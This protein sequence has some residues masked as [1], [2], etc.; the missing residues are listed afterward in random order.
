M[1]RIPER[2][3]QLFKSP[4]EASIARDF[5]GQ[6]LRENPPWIEQEPARALETL[7]QVNH[8]IE[9]LRAWCAQ[10][11]T[12]D[13]IQILR[14]ALRMASQHQRV[15]KRT[16]MLSPRAHLLVKTLAELE[17][18]SISEVIERH[19]GRTL[20]ECYGRTLRTTINERT[21][22]VDHAI[23]PSADKA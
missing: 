21:G 11:L 13:Q 22:Q 7:D 9:P 16:A 23:L 20:G 2:V 12:V 6:K 4:V 10:W 5:L 15:Y 1:D 17:D 19:L 18:L 3:S 14:Q 8:G